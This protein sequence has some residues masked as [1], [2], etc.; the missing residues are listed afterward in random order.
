M[1][2]NGIVDECL[3]LSVARS[4]P[5]ARDNPSAVMRLFFCPS[6]GLSKVYLGFWFRVDRGIL[7]SL[8]PKTIVAMA[9]AEGLSSPS[10]SVSLCSSG[11]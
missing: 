5:V 10:R 11:G 1:G 3:W 4:F 7:L 6:L 8:S 2:Q 9:A